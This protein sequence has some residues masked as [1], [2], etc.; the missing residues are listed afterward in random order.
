MIWLVFLEVIRGKGFLIVFKTFFIGFWIL[1][2]KIFFGFVIKFVDLVEL[3]VENEL[4]E[5]G[6]DVNFFLLLWFFFISFVVIDLFNFLV[7]NVWVFLI[8]ALKFIFRRVFDL[9]NFFCLIGRKWNFS[10]VFLGK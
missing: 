6:D 2:N 10:K 8:S 1:L 3:L 7:N 9:L 5:V 4:F